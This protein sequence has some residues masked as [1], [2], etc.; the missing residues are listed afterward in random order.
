MQVTSS[1]RSFEGHTQFWEHES[2]CT[3]S[4]MRFATFV[5]AGTVRGALIWLSG[6]G[7]DSNETNFITKAGAQRYL[8]E[9]GMMAICPDTS[10][11]DLDLPGV[12]D[13]EIFGEG[14]SYYVNATTPG[15]RDHYRMYDYVNDEIYGILQNHFGVKKIGISGYS[16]GGHGALTIGLKHAFKYTSLSAFAPLA[17]PTKN[18]RAQRAF[19]GY[20]GEDR[21][22]WE[23]HDATSLI[24]DAHR[25][26]NPI[27][28]DQGLADEFLETG[29]LTRNF[30]SA[31]QKLK[32]PLE[33][34]YREGYDHSYYFVA[35]F[36]E[37]HVRH[38]AKF[39]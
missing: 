12:R 20:F 19:R 16:M 10:P 3:R 1:H 33:I 31:C 17:N 21:E 26:P 7:R 6:R 2:R 15:Y 23:T 9:H 13:E 28:I 38:H 34:H 39:L 29:L 14:A 8:A 22:L 5:P 36:I 11:R 27:L 30:E 24:Y 37:S 32:Q 4:R 35:T 18:V 25:H